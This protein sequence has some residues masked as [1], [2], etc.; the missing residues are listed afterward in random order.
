MSSNT[1]GSAHSANTFIGA[2][3]AVYERSLIPWN[4]K[5][6]RRDQRLRCSRLSNLK[7]GFQSSCDFAPVSYPAEALQ[8]IALIGSTHQINRLYK[9]STLF[10]HVESYTQP[11]LAENFAH[12]SVV[13]RRTCN[14]ATVFIGE[15]N[16]P[17][18][19]KN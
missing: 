18:V 13:W 17:I 14:V 16:Q 15:K 12:N 11:E 4:S 10:T 1:R 8:A 9:P 6:S 3:C 7:S 19:D 5:A 2:T